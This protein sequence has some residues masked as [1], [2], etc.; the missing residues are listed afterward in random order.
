MAFWDKSEATSFL[1]CMRSIYPK[2][3][4]L[5]WVYV[6]Y[7]LALNTAMR[8][9]EIWGLR[10]M[11]VFEDQE[12]ILVRRQFNRVTNDFGPTK[13][14]RSRLV[15]CPKVLRSELM[16][17]IAA[18]NVSN[19][20]TILRN[21]NGKPICHDNFSDRQFHK[22][23]VKWGGRK[24]RFHDLRHSS[25]TLMI[26]N[27]VDL[28]TVKEICGHADIAT[29]MNYVHQIKGSVNIVAQTFSIE[30]EPLAKLA[31]LKVV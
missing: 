24:I 20:Q 1:D 14:K 18:D 7:L 26:A 22:D 30:P 3:H 31:A 25:T 19:M 10:A 5:H 28:K 15:P 2:G 11:D 9:G 21:E 16:G 17:F 13:S 6:V 23:L 8:A 12:T 4:S 27:N 29:T